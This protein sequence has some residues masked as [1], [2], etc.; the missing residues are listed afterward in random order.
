M[1]LGVERLHV[2]GGACRLGDPVEGGLHTLGKNGETGNHSGYGGPGH[3]VGDLHARHAIP[4]DPMPGI[5]VGRG[6]LDK[7]II[8]RVIRRHVNEV[9]YCYEQELTKNP[10][11]GGRIVAQFTIAAEGRVISSMVQNS[12]MGNVTIENCT[13]QAIRRWEF[14]KP[15]GGGL[16]IVSYPF[17]LA[18]AG[19]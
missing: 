13:I 8:R 18:P 15:T 2:L 14:P 3:G 17:V 1:H 11:L 6:S 19:Q 16:V 10:R 12:T 7:E 9:R 5:V 4:P